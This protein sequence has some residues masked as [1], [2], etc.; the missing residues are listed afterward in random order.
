[1]HETLKNDIQGCTDALYR[2]IN[3]LKWHLYYDIHNNSAWQESIQSQHSFQKHN[4]S[5][6]PSLI[7][8]FEVFFLNINNF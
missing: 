3:T 8:I 2:S 5:K 4:N 6:L 7:K 1:M